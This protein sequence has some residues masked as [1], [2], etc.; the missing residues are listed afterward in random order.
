MCS[1]RLQLAAAEELLLLPKA[2][3]APLRPG[4]AGS[5]AVAVESQEAA[6]VLVPLLLAALMLSSS[7]VRPPHATKLAL[8]LGPTCRA[9]VAWHVSQ[10]P[11]ASYAVHVWSG[12]DLISALWY[13]HAIGP[14]TCIA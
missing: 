4:L 6:P 2:L 13:C 8:Q 7:T 12:S 14:S 5:V 10:G 3:L 11:F 9:H 1:A